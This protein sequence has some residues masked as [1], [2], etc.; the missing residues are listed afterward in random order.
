M[1]ALAAQGGAPLRIALLA[2][3]GNPTCGG[4][5][6]YIRHL[7]RELAALGQRVTVLGGP[8]YPELG[9]GSERGT[10][11]VELVKL[12]SLDLYRQPDPFRWPRLREL[13]GPL[14]VLEVATMR[15]GGFPEP[16][17]FSLRARRWLASRRGAFDVVHDNQSLGSG[18][19]GMIEDGWPVL[20]S[21]HHPIDV[22]REIDLAHAGSW[23]KRA[24]LRRW[25]GFAAMQSRV[26]RRLPR[27]ITVSQASRDDIVALLGVAA[28]RIGVVPAGVDTEV[29][30][31]RQGIARI[32]GRIVTTASADVPIKG[33]AVLLEA[34][35][36]LRTERPDAHLVITGQLRSGGTTAPL[37]EQ[38]GLGG[39][40]SF[41]SGRS[42]AELAAGYAEAACA[43][44]PSLYEGFSLPAVE[45]L[46]CAAPL[47]AT[48][49]GALPE[50]VG[51][52]G[53]S[54][55]VVPPGD[56]SA[57][58]LALGRLLDE[59]ELGARL[60]SAGRRRVLERFTWSATAA[61]TLEEY[62]GLVAGRGRA[63][64]GAGRRGSC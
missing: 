58:A 17:T 63:L 57:L 18:L 1:T 11:R 7:A 52:D 45:A 10:G 9:A 38:L 13:A 59:P 4:Q 44:V 40:V 48:S 37:I 16:R 25:Y 26:A 28:S 5:G 64:P 20:A 54:A 39:A 53:T 14:E 49:G 15:A 43:V 12:P 6:V 3:R 35:A 33:L 30:T 2:Y 61:A 23:R 60:G 34:L 19:L 36:K 29:F 21:I 8:P 51:A 56:P 62:R 47:V 32:P 42:D 41:V 22:D 46:A 50:V 55:L 31:P 27:L 24:S